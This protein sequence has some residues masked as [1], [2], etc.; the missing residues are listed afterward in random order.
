MELHSPHNTDRLWLSFPHRGANFF[1]CPFRVH[2]GRISIV[3]A[4]SN[5]HASAAVYAGSVGRVT[6]VIG[7]VVDVQF[8]KDLPPIFNALEVNK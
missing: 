3:S 5:F 6:Q 4:R 8:D 1:L 7:A 2:C